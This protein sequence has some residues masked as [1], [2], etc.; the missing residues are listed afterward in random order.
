MAIA[1]RGCICLRRAFKGAVSASAQTSPPAGVRL[2][3]VP[4]GPTLAAAVAAL[5]SAPRWLAPTGPQALAE[6]RLDRFAD[7]TPDTL[8]WAA[9][10]LGADR[11]VITCRSV[12]EG[13]GVAG[14]ALRP[15][16]AQHALLRAAYALGVAFI[17]VE[18]ATVRA[19]PKLVAELNAPHACVAPQIEAA[20][21][22]LVV[23]V[24]LGVQEPP[25]D[26]AQMAQLRGEA[27]ALGASALKIVLPG[28]TV[29]QQLQA[30]A[31]MHTPHPVPLLLLVLG[32][33]G[34][35]SR[36]LVG[37][38]ANPGPYTP[39]RLD[40]EMGV[41]PGQPSWADADDLYRAWAVRAD[42]PVYGVIG[43]PIGHS[44]SPA[45]HRAALNALAQP[46]IYLPFAVPQGAEFV[47]FVTKLAPRLGV[48][49][50]SV[51]L[52]H[53]AHAAQVAA[54]KSAAVTATGA[55][56]TLI[57]DAT[58]PGVWAA[59]NTDVQAAVDA[60]ITTWV[61]DGAL[62]P[63]DGL[64][65]AGLRLLVLG[66]GGVARAIVYGMACAGAKVQVWGRRPDA[67]AILCAAL[68][69][70]IG[71]TGPAPV[72][73][74]DLKAALMCTDV[75]VHCTPV[76]MAPNDGAHA[77]LLSVADLSRLPEHALVF[78]TVYAPPLT[79]LLANA[80]QA[81]HRTLG[82]L[83]MLH[84]QAQGQCALFYAG[85]TA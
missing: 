3:V 6:L 67:A 48:R 25:M 72:V 47:A 81:G 53:K 11:L 37:R 5:Q 58:V 9:R 15:I 33:S 49:G 50:L 24:H 54:R 28:D 34:L 19:Y 79:Q 59:A 52:P 85:D 51:T 30:A 17:D 2:C 55:A 40:T 21:T 43:W 31:W 35:W 13:G 8:A 66:T 68:G 10:E 16:A 22:R 29:A 74:A 38:T 27:L 44:K 64:P 75:V 41:A 60:L 69:E 18:L 45:L 80:H 32:Q 65:L 20:R 46:G 39:V 84:R 76:G 42:T 14:R 62:G 82:G 83:D 56:N 1:A 77:S 61:P 36:L 71:G 7:A 73:A 57:A 26:D 78:D 63:R 23:S 70:H 4:Q 12:A